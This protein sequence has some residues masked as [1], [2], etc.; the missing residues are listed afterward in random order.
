MATKI[1]TKDYL[2]NELDLPYD[3]DLVIS[4]KITDTGRWSIHHSLIFKDPADDKFYKVSYSV[5]AT[6]NQPEAPWEYDNTIT[7]TQVVKRS[8]IKSEFVPVDS[9][10]KDIS[11]MI[12]EATWQIVASEVERASS[13]EELTEHVNRILTSVFNLEIPQMFQQPQPEVEDVQQEQIDI[14]TPITEL[15]ALEISSDYA[16]FQKFVNKLKNKL[17]DVFYLD[18]ET[19]IGD[20]S[21]HPVLT[22]TF[23]VHC[24][25]GSDNIYSLGNLYQKYLQNKANEVAKPLKAIISD[26]EA[27]YDAHNMEE[28][29]DE[30]DLE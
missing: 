23:V 28:E 12:S 9:D 18:Q 24:E 7:G 11:Q 1:F 2:V 25:D 3:E 20:L 4:D 13:E 15:S 14:P 19:T 16:D 5:G 21:D 22:D 6:E 30:P 10:R 8:L 27:D 26:I 17:D 29:T